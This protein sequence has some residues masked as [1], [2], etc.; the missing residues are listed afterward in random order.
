MPAKDLQFNTDARAGARPSP[1]TASPS[2][3]KSSCLTRWRTWALRWSRKP[4]PRR[5]TSPAM[6][7]PPPQCS[8]VEEARGLETTIDVERKDHTQPANGA[9]GGMGGM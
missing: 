6:A 9:Q 5:P 4:P 1:G 2:P 8:R 7:V 3:R